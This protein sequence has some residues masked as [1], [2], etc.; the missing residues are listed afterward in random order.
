MSD[1]PISADIERIAEQ[2]TRGEDP[3]GT[4]GPQT[5]TDWDECAAAWRFL[6][7]RHKAD[8]DRLREALR[9]AATACTTGW[10]PDGDSIG[11]NVPTVMFGERLERSITAESPGVRLMRESVERHQRGESTP[12]DVGAVLTNLD[13]IAHAITH[14]EA[15]LRSL[16]AEATV[17]N[18]LDRAEGHADE[19]AHALRL[20][21]GGYDDP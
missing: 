21:S 14:A 2:L 1:R 12:V 20:I 8:T 9:L 16:H 7:Y 18:L 19:L 10:L 3:W 17:P 13:V 11:Q 15:F 6:A 4:D 5:P